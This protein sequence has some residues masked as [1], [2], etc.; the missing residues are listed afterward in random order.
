MDQKCMDFKYAIDG[1]LQYFLGINKVWSED[2]DHSCWYAE[3]ARWL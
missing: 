2:R 1:K 3:T